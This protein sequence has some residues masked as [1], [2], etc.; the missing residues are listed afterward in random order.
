V[1]PRER[2]PLRCGACGR[3]LEG[4]ALR[5]PSGLRIVC[6]DCGGTSWQSEGPVIVFPPNVRLIRSDDS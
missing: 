6:P 4:K 2:W 3:L 5:A 1:T